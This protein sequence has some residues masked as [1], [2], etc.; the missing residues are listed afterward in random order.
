MN[1]LDFDFGAVVTSSY[2]TDGFL[3]VQYDA[4]GEQ[5]SGVPPYEAHFPYGLYARP[6]D[7]VV[8]ATQQNGLSTGQPNPAKAAQVMYCKEGNQGHAFP[9]EDPRVIAQLPLLAKGEC[10]L[11]AAAGQFFRLVADGSFAMMTTDGG[12]LTGN[13]VQ[14]T[15]G[16]SGW[17]RAGP[18]GKETFDQNGYH[19][20]VGTSGNS[21]RIDMNYL[22]GLP[23]PLDVVGSSI[24]FQADMI[25]LK[26]KIVS[27][28]SGPAGQPVAQAAPLVAV[29]QGIGVN[30]A[31]IATALASAIPASGITQAQAQA[32]T[33]A[34]VASQ[35]L[36]QGALAAIS[37]TTA[38]S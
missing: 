12:G 34:T 22:A 28:G 9:L 17:L 2:D 31:A 29:L 21:P 37:T 19:L 8:D 38:I 7:P 4:F 1:Q 11:Y 14:Y 30:L 35:T 6:L 16:P 15:Q 18:M 23:A 25:E 27:L 20:R 13:T 32:V 5:K 3:R 26:A 24:V 33:A 10:A 36:I